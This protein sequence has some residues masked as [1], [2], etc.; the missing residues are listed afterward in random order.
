[1]QDY[2]KKVVIFSMVLWVFLFCMDLIIG[3]DWPS[4]TS[5]R[6]FIWFPTVVIGLFW[7]IYGGSKN[8]TDKKDS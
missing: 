4:Q 1:M 8:K 2:F 3:I 5:K 6:A 7:L